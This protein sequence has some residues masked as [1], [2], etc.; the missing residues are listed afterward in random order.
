MRKSFFILIILALAFI[1]AGC[2]QSQ[3]NDE[4]QQGLDKAKAGDYA[5]AL[6]HT[7]RCLRISPD[8]V[9]ALLLHG[10]CL[11]SLPSAGGTSRANAFKH[12]E[13]ATKLAPERFDVW[14]FYG[15]SLYENGMDHNAIQPLE[16]ALSLI[17]AKDRDKYYSSILMMLGRCAAHNN[18][19]Q[20]ALKYLQ[21][22][23]VRKPYSNMPDTYNSLGV[24]AVKRNK[25]SEAIELFAQAYK[26]DKNDPTILQ[27]IAVTCDLYLNQPAVA[28]SYYAMALKKLPAKEVILRQRIQNR[29]NK[30]EQTAPSR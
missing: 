9:N 3:I 11:Y 23:R 4:L 5:G 16:T 28:K 14:Y 19:Q 17:P 21:P 30:L 20:K 1:L 27:N 29:L 24:L 6:V 13:K 22:L 15:W 7:E 25:P 2:T 10:F 26:L 8:S 18:L 12:L